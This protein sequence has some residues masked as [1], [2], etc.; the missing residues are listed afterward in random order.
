MPA[1]TLNDFF[2][3]FFYGHIRVDV[4]GK[5]AIARRSD[6]KK[7]MEGKVIVETFIMS[8]DVRRKHE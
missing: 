6:R 8:C 5:V 7:V 2:A 3:V 4:G 1:R